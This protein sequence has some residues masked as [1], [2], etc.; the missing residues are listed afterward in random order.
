MAKNFEIELRGPLSSD[1]FNRLNDF[2]SK[3]GVLK[4]KRNRILI[5]YSTFLPDQGIKER[6]KDIRLRVTNKKPEIIIKVGNWGGSDHREE[7]SVFAEE[8][9]FDTLVKSFH[10]LGYSKGV[11]CVRNSSIYTYKDIEFAVVEVPEHSY[12]FEAEKI[13]NSEPEKEEALHDI[14]A[15][16]A[17]LGLHFFDDANFFTYIETLNKEANE[18]FDF[19]NYTEGYF[20]ARFDL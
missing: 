19:K 17:E 2:L 12:Y 7:L 10:V 5:D 4:E 14:H 13:V 9:S 16:C 1:A 15:V 8:G 6:T 20:K 3:N 11:L 18:I